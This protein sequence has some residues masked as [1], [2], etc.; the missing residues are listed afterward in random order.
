MDL[1]AVKDG[2]VGHLTGMP[3]SCSCIEFLKTHNFVARIVHR[4]L[5][6][7]TAQP[8]KSQ[9]RPTQLFKHVFFFAFNTT[10]YFKSSEQR[11]R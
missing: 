8:C 4:Q 7:N 10:V 9:K 2:M 3:L 11:M 1:F 5:A 6:L